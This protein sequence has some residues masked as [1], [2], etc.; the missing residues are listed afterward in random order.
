MLRVQQGASTHL[1]AEL[2]KS[3]AGVNIVRIPYKGAGP[4]LNDLIGGEVQLM[5]ANARRRWRR[6]SSRAD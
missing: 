6:I 1:A 4:A 2:F 5:F 3:M